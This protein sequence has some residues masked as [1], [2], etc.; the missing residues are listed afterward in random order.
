MHTHTPAHTHT[1]THTCIYIYTYSIHI[2]IHLYIYMYIY[3]HT[4][5][6]TYIYIH[7]YIHPL[8]Y[9]TL[10]YTHTYKHTYIN[11]HTHIYIYILC[12]HTYII[13]LIYIHTYDTIQLHN[14]STT[15]G[16]GHWGLPRQLRH[17]FHGL[18]RLQ[19]IQAIC[20]GRPDGRAVR[21]Q[22]EVTQS[23][24]VWEALVLPRKQ[25]GTTRYNKVWRWLDG[26][27]GISWNEE[28]TSTEDFWRMFETCLNNVWT[29]MNR[30]YSQCIFGRWNGSNHLKSFAC[31][32][33][34]KTSHYATC[35]V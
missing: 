1:Y 9:I 6:H 22:K 5:T 13:Y 31:K 35:M 11:T 23:C 18:L 27:F 3:V 8:H 4:H 21:T 12:I 20:E 7:T 26:C 15:Q 10:H 34:Q 24:R 25:Q 30:V 2:C 29:Y 32:S 33:A 19:R 17:A 16:Q 14:P 28:G